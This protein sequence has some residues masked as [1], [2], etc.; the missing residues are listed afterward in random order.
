MQIS[1]IEYAR[2]VL[3]LQGANSTEFEPNTKNPCV[4]FMPEV[5][6]S[7]LWCC[8]LFSSSYSIVKSPALYV[9]VQSSK[10]HMIVYFYYLKVVFE[11]EIYIV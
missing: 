9:V 11:N 6:N 1:V 5:G 10:T 3:G 2:N 8:K 4:I 7:F